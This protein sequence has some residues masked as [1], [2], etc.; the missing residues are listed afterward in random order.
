[1]WLHLDIRRRGIVQRLRES[2]VCGQYRTVRVALRGSSLGEDETVEGA[3]D[4]LRGIH[5]LELSDCGWKS[6]HFGWLSLPSLQGACPLSCCIRVILT[7]HLHASDLKTLNIEI[8]FNHLVPAN[9]R[10]SF[11]LRT[12]TLRP[13]T[14][15]AALNRTI[16]H[17]SSSSLLSLTLHLPR[18]ESEAHLDIGVL[19]SLLVRNRLPSLSLHGAVPGLGPILSTFT[20][21]N[22]LTLHIYSTND[23]AEYDTLLAHLTTPVPSLR[24][25]VAHLVCALD[26]GFVRDLSERM[27]GE[28]W[29]GVTEVRF[30]VSRGELE[31]AAE[32]TDFL[33]MCTAKVIVVKSL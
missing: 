3:V 26:R 27:R 20:S 10:P 15:S 17:S 19:S 25:A 16:L 6:Y 23:F 1:M 22:S 9:I 18:G 13:S 5:W 31:E 12:R 14:T 24:L 29:Q 2:P 8:P 33:E 21:L 7:F 32:G 4:K 30:L 28:A 11:R